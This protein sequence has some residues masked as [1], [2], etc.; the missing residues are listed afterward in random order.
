MSADMIIQ[1]QQTYQVDLVGPARQDYKWQARAGEGF[2][3]ADA[4]LD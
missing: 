1:S 3:T 4:K 2:A